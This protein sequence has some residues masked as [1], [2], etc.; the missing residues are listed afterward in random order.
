M[1]TK[2][3]IKKAEDHQ[4]EVEQ[5]AQEILK[6]PTVKEFPRTLL[7][8]VGQV[9]FQDN[10]WTGI[11]FL[12]GIFWGSYQEGSPLVCWGC[13]VGVFISTITGYVL[14]LPDA[15]GAQGL[16]GFN[17]ALV[18]CAF[19]TF[20]G[21]TVWMWIG[22]IICAALS[23]IAK[24]GMDNILGRW[25]ISSFTFPF[26]AC[27]WIF[28]LSARV[29][30]GFPPVDMGSP[31]FPH[32][33]A[34]S[35]SYVGVIQHFANENVSLGFGDLVLYW[36]RGISQVFLIKSWVCGIFFLAALAVSSWRACLWAAIASALSLFIAIIWQG[37]GMDIANGLYGFSAVL[38]GIAL[39]ATFCN[40]SWKAAIWC[41]CGIIATVFVQAAMNVFFT[42]MGFPTLTG[43]FCVATWIFLFPAYGFFEP[44]PT[45]A[46]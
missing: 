40:F 8:G 11:L 21:N 18:G 12:C 17:G 22:L 13:L 42:P 23:T 5:Q 20:L 43:P 32:M 1:D 10:M 41:V 39:G 27:T 28:L 26:V 15:G 3:I 25:K 36:L 46:K 16:W 2:E 31:E 19:P 34:G 44:K 45:P 35:S 4:Q 6:R 37:P 14:R 7:R 30:S 38:T 29:F 33:V 24:S 9:M